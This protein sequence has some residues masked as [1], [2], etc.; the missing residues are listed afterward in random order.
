MRRVLLSFVGA[1]AVAAGLSFGSVAASAAVDPYYTTYSVF[2]QPKQVTVV[3]TTLFDLYG[4]WPQGFEP[5]SAASNARP[6]N[7]E[8][9]V[10]PS[11]SGIGFVRRATLYWKFNSGTGF[12]EPKVTLTMYDYATVDY[13]NDPGRHH[14]SGRRPLH[15]SRHQRAGWHGQPDHHELIDVNDWILNDARSAHGAFGRLGRA[16]FALCAFPR[17]SRLCRS[18]V[19]RDDRAGGRPC[20]ADA[21]ECWRSPGA[22]G[23]ASARLGVPVDDRDHADRRFTA[24]LRTG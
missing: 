15:Q 21:P 17:R 6:A 7:E 14:R 3:R 22:A 24:L 20:A 1:A 18:P 16:R 19:R 13:L 10:L 11:G 4:Y 9:G 12:Y 5:I 2:G 8:L 23:V